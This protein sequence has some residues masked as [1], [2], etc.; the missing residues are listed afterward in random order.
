VQS[1]ELI[2]DALSPY[3][4][5]DSD[6]LLLFCG[7]NGNDGTTNPNCGDVALVDCDATEGCR[8]NG[9][10]SQCLTDPA[11]QYKA[12]WR[13]RD[14]TC[15]GTRIVVVGVD[16]DGNDIYGEEAYQGYYICHNPNS[17]HNYPRT[18]CQPN[19][20][21]PPDM[22][23]SMFTSCGWCCQTNDDNEED[24]KWD[25]DECS[26]TCTTGEDEEIPGFVMM[27]ANGSN[28]K[29]GWSTKEQC[30]AAEDVKDKLDQHWG[31][32]CEEEE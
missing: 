28:Q 14:V 10:G 32:S 4:S 25:D 17:F 8:L 29:K 21:S 20:E 26:V 9:N 5:T 19:D 11:I 2:I 18:H 16:E 3:D 15:E 7:G 30:V 31:S 23:M 13:G 22:D 12:D 27:V 6:D 24:N 1:A